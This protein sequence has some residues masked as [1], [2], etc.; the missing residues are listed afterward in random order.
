METSPHYPREIENL[1]DLLAVEMLEVP[2]AIREPVL[3]AHLAQVFADCSDD[4]CDE[5]GLP[6]AAATICRHI[7]AAVRRIEHAG[8]GRVGL[9]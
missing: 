6:H 5:T 3:R 2:R 9:A 1:I 4:R 8:G 7:L